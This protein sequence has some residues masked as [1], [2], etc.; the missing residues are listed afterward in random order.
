MYYINA[1]PDESGKHGNPQ[2]EP[3]GSDC[4]FLPEDLLND[5]IANDGKKELIVAS[6]RVILGFE[7]DK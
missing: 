6:N 2:S 5:Y 7:S 4:L 3:W 1:M